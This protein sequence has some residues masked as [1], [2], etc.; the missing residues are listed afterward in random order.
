MSIGDQAPFD[1]CASVR[2]IHAV[3]RAS[4]AILK[5]GSRNEWFYCR[6]R[7]ERLTDRGVCNRARIRASAR[8]GEHITCQWIHHH[9]VAAF[10]LKAVGRASKSALA[11]LLQ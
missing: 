6:S 2:R 7:L 4:A 8:H 3:V 1:D 10:G 11:N 5:E 9:D